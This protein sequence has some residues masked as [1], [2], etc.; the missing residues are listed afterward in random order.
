[1]ALTIG[2]IIHD[3]YRIAGLLGQGG[4]G[5]VYRAW[6]L[7]LKIPVAIKE[8]LD[9]SNDAQRQF[10]REAQILARLSHPNL[11]RVTDYFFLPNHGQYLVMDFVEGEDLESKVQ[12]EGPLAEPQAIVWI[13]Q[14]CDALAY[15]HGQ[16][17]PVIH[18][19]IKPANVRIT[20]SGKAM[21]VD[22]GIAKLFDPHL[23]TTIGAKAVTPGFS[24]PEQYGTG[25]TDA[26]SDIYSLGATLYTLLTGNTPPDSTL[27]V[28][29]AKEFT[30]PRQV[31]IEISPNTELAILKCME[32]SQTRRF[33]NVQELRQALNATNAPPI[34][35]P[36]QAQVEMTAFAA[37]AAKVSAWQPADQSAGSNVSPGSTAPPEAAGLPQGLSIQP[38]AASSISPGNKRL[39]R[40]FIWAAAGWIIAK[41]FF[42]LEWLVCLAILASIWR[43]PSTSKQRE[44]QKAMLIYWIGTLIVYLTIPAVANISGGLSFVLISYFLFAG[45]GGLAIKIS[46]K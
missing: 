23:K 41:F 31:R 12:R 38:A 35:I 39:T 8:N 29:G 11:P 22:F 5:A 44:F 42:Y 40:R 46:K 21:L 13:S 28:V 27:I 9:T 32:I 17:T 6:H 26:R 33:Q 14:I 37:L 19:D 25:Q 2:Q 7:T 43:S 10:E 4:M 30:P 18:R 16:P 34:H 24:P 20:A 45:L 15:L 36:D 3:R 1:M